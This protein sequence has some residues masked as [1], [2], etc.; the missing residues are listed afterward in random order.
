VENTLLH[1]D[2]ANPSLS[3]NKSQTRDLTKRIAHTLRH[4]YG[5]GASGKR[6]YVTCIAGGS[7]ILPAVFYG[8]VA[9]GGIFSSVTS[10]STVS[11]L[12][13]L[14]KLAPSDLVICSPETKDVSIKAA[15][16]CGVP[17]DR[18]LIV[19]PENATLREVQSGRNVLGTQMLDW[20]R[21]TT[22][23]AVENTPVCLIYSSGTTGLPKGV[24]LS[25]RNMVAEATIS[26]DLIKAQW[27]EMAP[28]ADYRTLA[29]LPTAHIAG[30]QG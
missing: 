23:E 9:S 19:D 7:Y 10:S 13:R 8:C 26:C 28:D 22:R 12:A 30:M 11:E 15:Q 14:I 1:A 25:H 24:P 6:D 20:Q 2:A 4:R 17:A 16:E 3:L 27:K 29:H 21:L 5:I 18:V